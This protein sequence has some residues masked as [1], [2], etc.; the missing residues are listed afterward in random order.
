VRLAAALVVLLALAGATEAR[1]ERREAA[2]G[3]EG[4]LAL[5]ALA[6]QDATAFRLVTFGVGGFGRFGLTDSLDLELRFDFSLFRAKIDET[7]DLQG[8]DLVGVRYF[9]AEQY[10]ASIGARYKLVSGYFLAPYLE[11]HAG[12]MWLVLRDQQ[13]LSPAGEDFGVEVADEGQGALTLTAGVAVDYRLFDWVFVGVAVRWVELF[14]AG[15][16]QRYL[17]V[18]LQAAIYW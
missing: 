8:R 15:L 3:V 13:F 9:R 14:G 1:A 5:P 18:P 7:R 12:L 6:S 16:H 11:A 17:S 4:G 2:A 10:H